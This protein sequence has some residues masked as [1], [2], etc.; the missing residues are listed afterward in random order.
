MGTVTRV[1]AERGR[2]M[3]TII[4]REPTTV[5]RLERIWTMSVAMQVEITSMS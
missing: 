5:T 1:R 4:T 3:V 2:E